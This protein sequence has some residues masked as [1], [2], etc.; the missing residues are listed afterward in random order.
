LCFGSAPA[1][2]GAQCDRLLKLL[3]ARIADAVCFESS[4]LTT[5]NP[6][7]TP[8]N[9]SLAGLPP[10][11]FTP[12]TDRTVISPPAGFRTPILR[13]LPGIQLQARMADD[14]LGEARILIRLP[15]D[16][17]RFGGSTRHLHR[18]Q[19]NAERIEVAALDKLDDLVGETVALPVIRGLQNLRNLVIGV[20]HRIHKGWI[21]VEYVGGHLH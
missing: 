10:F 14:P 12:Q 2:A 11:V 21:R 1:S 20:P 18:A 3:G 17:L 19:R 6:A 13:T 7:T 9:D 4:D 8:A 15:D 16:I 5:N